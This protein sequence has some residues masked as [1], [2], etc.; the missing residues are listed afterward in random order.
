MHRSGYSRT[1][2]HLVPSVGEASEPVYMYMQVTIIFALNI[3][4]HFGTEL[5]RSWPSTSWKGQ[6]GSHGRFSRSRGHRSYQTATS[7]C[8]AV[9]RC[10]P[11]PCPTDTS[12][13]EW[14]RHLS[15]QIMPSQSC[16]IYTD[17]CNVTK[18]IS[19]Y[20]HFVCVDKTKSIALLTK[21]ILVIMTL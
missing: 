7:R 17:M 8:W 3:S 2:P 18:T 11:V 10:S 20:I 15:C 4:P 1:A 5:W 6:S 13:A 12:P 19:K 9:W 14:R 16:H 21:R